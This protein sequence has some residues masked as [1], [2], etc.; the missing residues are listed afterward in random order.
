MSICDEYREHV[1]RLLTRLHFAQSRTGG[2]EDSEDAPEIDIV[3]VIQQEIAVEGLLEKTP[4]NPPELRVI[5]LQ[6]RALPLVS[7]VLSDHPYINSPNRY[8]YYPGLPALES[9]LREMLDYMPTAQRIQASAMNNHDIRTLAT[10]RPVAA[11]RRA[12]PRRTQIKTNLKPSERRAAT[13]A[14]VIEELNRLRG[15]MT[16][17]E[18]D[19]E[20]LRKENPHFLTFKLAKRFPELKEKVLNLQGHRQHKRLAQELAA[21]H[22]GAKLN[23]ILIDWKK[24]KPSKYR[25]LSHK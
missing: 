7:K 8:D 12:R 10:S 11:T 13:V 19:Y 24:H 20:A 14:K 18:S 17:G 6:I 21:A 15:R 1:E 3:T 23:T 16:G 2:Y 5:A 9:K 25:Q 4:V 22:H